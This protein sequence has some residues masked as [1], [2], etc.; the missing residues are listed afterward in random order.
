MYT[1]FFEKSYINKWITEFDHKKRNNY[2][3]KDFKKSTINSLIQEEYKD[4]HVNDVIFLK[5]KENESLILLSIKDN[6]LKHKQ[7]IDNG[8]MNNTLEFDFMYSKDRKIYTFI[9]VNPK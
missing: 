3:V 5:N 8:V 7:E 1:R 4:L 6:Y 2:E 9:I